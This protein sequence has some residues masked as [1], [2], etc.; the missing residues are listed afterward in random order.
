M[1]LL[2]PPSP[3][4]LQPN[5]QTGLAQLRKWLRL[6]EYSATTAATTMSL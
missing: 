4:T 3:F 1:R 6:I 5:L 2:P